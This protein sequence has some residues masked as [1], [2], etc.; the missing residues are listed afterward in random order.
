M[1]KQQTDERNAHGRAEFGGRVEHCGGQPA[2]FLRKPAT[3]SGSAERENGG[4]TD[5]EQKARRKQADDILGCRGGECGGA[6][7]KGVDDT[8]ATQTEAIQQDAGRQLQHGV[9]PAVGSQQITEGDCGQAEPLVQRLLADRDIHSVQIAD[10]HAQGQEPCDSPSAVRR[11][12]I[13]WMG[14]DRG[15][16]PFGMCAAGMLAVLGNIGR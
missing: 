13:R 7:D 6:P 8:H 5:A 16:L 10:H 4:F 2:F 9:R 15:F 11:A 14:A 12:G 1:D 3:H